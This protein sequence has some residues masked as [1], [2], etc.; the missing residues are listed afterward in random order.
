MIN[1]IREVIDQEFG[2]ADDAGLIIAGS[3]ASCVGQPIPF[4]D[5]VLSC[6]NQ[7]VTIGG[8]SFH[9]IYDRNRLDSIIFIKSDEDCSKYLSLIAINIINLKAYYDEKFEKLNFI[10]S[11]LFDNA[12]PGD[13]SLRLKELHIPYDARRVVFVI[14]TEKNVDSHVHDVIQSLFPN[15]SKD[16]IIIL[17]NETTVLL[18]ELKDEGDPSGI[19]KTASDIVNTLNSELI[20]KAY[21][22]VGS[23]VDNIA[24]IRRSFREA[25]TALE[26]GGV[27]NNDKS[28]FRYDNLGIGR[29]IYQ[30]PDDLCKMFLHEIF[31]EGAFESLDGET[32][33]TIQEFFE[34][35]L[36]VSE[37]SRQLYVHRN[38]LVYRLDK[39]QKVT[40]L[41]IRKFDDAIIFEAAM[42]VKKYIDKKNADRNL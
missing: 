34:N 22:G 41:D 27:F 29:L 2:V 23:P 40:G 17:N 38:T 11:I 31:R 3:D 33:H 9:K 19:E 5:K 6:K 8:C 42:L 35:N 20:I 10:K 24:D 26:V 13:L 28:V 32:I 39:I 30:L 12:L 16:F 15:K 21:I 37:T 4:A 1:Q 14:K 36:N 25:N 18:K 7:D